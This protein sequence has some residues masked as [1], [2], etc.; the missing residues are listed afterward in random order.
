MITFLLV[1]G[2]V[3][4]TRFLT[5]LSFILLTYSYLLADVD[6]SWVRRYNEYNYSSY[7][8]KAAMDRD[9]NIYVAGSNYD[10]IILKY[11]PSGALEWVRRNGEGMAVDLFVDEEGSV[12]ATGYSPEDSLNA[13]WTTVKYYNNG[14]TAW[15]QKYHWPGSH[16]GYGYNL[17]I[18]NT[19]NVFVT[20]IFND[21]GHYY[22]GL[23]KYD[24][25][26]EIL[27]T[28]RYP[29]TGSGSDYGNAVTVSAGDTS[30][31]TGE[32]DYDGLSHSLT[33]KY[34]PN[35]D[36]VWVRRYN[37]TA[38]I[39][40]YGC[41]IELD[42]L[43]GVYVSGISYR[44]LSD[45]H[46]NY[47][48]LKY[49]VEGDTLFAA[50]YITLIDNMG[51]NDMILDN[52]GN[53]YI[54]GYSGALKIDTSGAVNW[55]LLRPVTSIACDT[56]NNVY[57]GGDADVNN[58]NFQVTKFSPYM[59]TVWIATVNTGRAGCALSVAVNNLGEVA[60]TGV[61]NLNHPLWDIITM[62]LIEY[63]S[64]VND[65]LPQYKNNFSINSY[66]NPFNAQTTIKYTLP[67]SSNV[68]LDIFDITGRKVETLLSAYQRDGEHAITWNAE[69]R[70]SGIYFYRL[71]AG[72]T[73]R[74]A[75]CIL[76]K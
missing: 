43:T 31:V 13:V 17:K 60:V 19:G 40:G 42:G 29:E 39:G 52:T 21:S 59:D 20:G 22:L 8:N 53:I 2:E 37:R 5:I 24:F 9:G 47:F 50:N 64:P 38:N 68:S 66:P 54:A 6:T 72:E 12:F 67:A 75:N 3:I 1:S 36:T 34:L 18:G 58:G 46:N 11:S 76:L 51:N 27:W 57:L 32:E 45:N 23:I 41:A 15:I 63:T 48:L 25:N 69:N 70:P 74:T 56:F 4:M 16:A 65:N 44:T 62:K 30:Y 61:D 33:I 71:K 73:T 10:F 26:G 35:G 49:N 14:D 7:G 28:K 55:L